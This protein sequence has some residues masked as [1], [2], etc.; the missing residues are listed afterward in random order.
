M[1]ASRIENQIE[2]CPD[3]GIVRKAQQAPA[4]VA[5]VQ[6]HTCMRNDQANITLQDGTLKR[7]LRCRTQG[8][9]REIAESF[10]Y[11]KQRICGSFFS[12]LHILCLYPKKGKEVV[13]VGW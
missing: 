8:A 10:R 3:D 11:T 4:Q 6:I 9:R 7:L 12:F 2:Y 13:V 5:I 1:L